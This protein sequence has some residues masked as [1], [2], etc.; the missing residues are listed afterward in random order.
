MVGRDM[1]WHSLG[2]AAAT[3]LA[4]CAVLS[5]GCYPASYYYPQNQ[6]AKGYSVPQ[7]PAPPPQPRYYHY[8]GYYGPAYYYRPLPYYYGP[9]PYYRG[10]Y[11]YRGGHHHRGGYYRP[12]H[13]H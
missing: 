13:H 11:Y 2:F 6:D 9:V 10:G 1:K 3:L 7:E 4:A 12:R 8:Y 5:V